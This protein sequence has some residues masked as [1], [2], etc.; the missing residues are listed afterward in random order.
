MIESWV[1]IICDQPYGTLYIGVTSNIRR[2]AYE[3][4]EGSVDGFSKRYGLKLLVY[5][6]TFTDIRSAIEREKQLKKWR[7]AWKIELIQSLNPAWTD[8]YETL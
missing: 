1:Y 8:L 2:R 4:R 3:H 5:V 7:R 6:E